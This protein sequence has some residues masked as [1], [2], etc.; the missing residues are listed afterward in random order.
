M[1]F[2]DIVGYLLFLAGI[3][4]AIVGAF[5]KGLLWI[6]GGCV[7][8]MLGAMLIRSGSRRRE[9]GFRD[10]GDVAEALLDSLD[11]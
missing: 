10:S 2:E 4:I 8:A 6:A 7:L 1:T 5:H 11:D 3:A 9:G